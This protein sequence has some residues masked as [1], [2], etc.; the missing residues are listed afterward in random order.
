MGFLNVD[1]RTFPSIIFTTNLNNPLLPKHT[2]I[3]FFDSDFDKKI[4]LLFISDSN[5]VL[6]H[7]GYEAE[8]LEKGEC[9]LRIVS[10]TAEDE[11]QWTC[12][13]KL[14]G[15]KQEDQDFITLRRNGKQ[16]NWMAYQTTK[17]LITKNWQTEKKS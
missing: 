5:A 3:K 17:S 1:E 12:V 6:G 11:G 15:K 7:Y 13:A 10:G 9:G 4:Q 2:V 14:Q 8:G 16:F